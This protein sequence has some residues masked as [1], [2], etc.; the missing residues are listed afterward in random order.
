MNIESILDLELFEAVCVEGNFAKAARKTGSSLPT[1]SKRISRLERALKVTLFERTTRTIRLTEAGNRFRLRAERILTELRAAEKETV[2]EKELKGKIRITAP[3]PFATRILPPL[4]AEFRNQ[5]PEIQLEVVFGNEKFNLIE[6]RF[7]LGIRIMKPIRGER[8][9]VLLPNRIIAVTSPNYLEKVGTPSRLSD[10]AKHSILFVDEQSNVRIPEL[11]KTI[12][13]LSGDRG[14]RSNNGSFL[15]EFIARGGSGILFRS[16][17]DVEE[18]I[19]SGKIKRI[20]PNHH[21]QSE[22]SVCLLFPSG[23]KPPKRV[24]RFGEFLESKIFPGKRGGF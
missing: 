19:E 16:I 4:F 22:A 5:N 15:A 12:S 3:A 7:D 8:C 20:F 23:E 24:L 1:I 17:W 6:D 18:Q 2:F 11:K 9:R 13:E 21:W 10:L 14:I